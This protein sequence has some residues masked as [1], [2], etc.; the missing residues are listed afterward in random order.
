[1]KPRVGVCSSKWTPVPLEKAK[2]EVREGKE[3]REVGRRSL[4]GKVRSFGDDD[5]QLLDGER[6]GV[7]REARGN[8]RFLSLTIGAR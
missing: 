7:R 4:E 8:G 6:K 3:G 2:Q 1:M 5:G